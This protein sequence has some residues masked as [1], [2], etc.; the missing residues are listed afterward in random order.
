MR[1]IRVNQWGGP[2]VLEL[3]EDAPMPEPS[4]H[5]QLVRVTRTSCSC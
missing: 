3:L 2:E 5:E 1:A 4:G